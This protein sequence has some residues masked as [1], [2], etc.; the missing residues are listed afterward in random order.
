[1]IGHYVIQTADTATADRW[2]TV[3]EERGGEKGYFR[4][5]QTKR[6][7]TIDLWFAKH[8]TFD[9]DPGAWYRVVWMEPNGAYGVIHDPVC[10]KRAVYRQRLPSRTTMFLGC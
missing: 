7:A 9:S 8:V 4:P 10:V 6:R 5:L 1:M 2:V 3:Y